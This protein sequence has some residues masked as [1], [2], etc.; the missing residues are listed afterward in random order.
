MTSFSMLGKGNACVTL[1]KLKGRSGISHSKDRKSECSWGLCLA[2]WLCKHVL[3]VTD[4]VRSA[5]GNGRRHLGVNVDWHRE[6]SKDY[7]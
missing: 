6:L 5:I 2:N 1:G 4:T 3:T 7:G